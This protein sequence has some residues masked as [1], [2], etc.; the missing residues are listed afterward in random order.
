MLWSTTTQIEL[1][2]P[3]PPPC[4]SCSHF[5]NFPVMRVY[6]DLSRRTGQRT[7]PG[8][9]TPPLVQYMSARRAT[10]RVDTIKFAIFDP[11]L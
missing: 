4:L 3:N 1:S 8:W 7:P 6:S 9:S 5:R 11:Y 2:T 10:H